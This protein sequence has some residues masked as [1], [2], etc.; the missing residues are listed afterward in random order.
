MLKVRTPPIDHATGL[1]WLRPH[2]TAYRWPMRI[3]PLRLAA[4]GI[5][6][7]AG[8]GMAA[9]AIASNGTDLR[10]GRSGSLRDLVIRQSEQLNAES[11]ATAALRRS[12]ARLATQIGGVDLTDARR[13]EAALTPLAGMTAVHGPGVSVTLNDAPRNAGLDDVDPDALVIHQQD[14]QAVVNALWRGGAEAVMVMDQRLIATSAVKC[15]GNTLLLQGRVYS[16]PYVIQAIGDAD[17]LQHALEVDPGTQLIHDLAVVYGLGYDVASTA[18]ISMP[19]FTG[20]LT[21]PHAQTL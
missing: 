8:F 15:V 11:V 20:A 18:S 17:R 1:P 19:A 2:A 16:P 3:A 4:G 5:A 6:L 9:S 13:E 7:L 12:V 10:G 14:V 21:S